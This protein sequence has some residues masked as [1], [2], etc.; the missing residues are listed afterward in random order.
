[1]RLRPMRSSRELLY[2]CSICTDH[3]KQ[4][5]ACM[6]QTSTFAI[7]IVEASHQI[8]IHQDGYDNHVCLQICLCLLNDSQ[9]VK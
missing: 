6:V 9:P 8:K 7:A 5:L 1:M 4:Q 3:A 2:L